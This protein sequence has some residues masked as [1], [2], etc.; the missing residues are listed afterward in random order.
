MQSDRLQSFRD[1]LSCL[2]Y[3]VDWKNKILHILLEVIEYG[4]NKGYILPKKF[5]DA[6]FELVRFSSSE[7]IKTS[8]KTMTKNEFQDFISSFSKEDKYLFLFE[9]LIF[10]GCRIGE[11]CALQWKDF[12]IE[13]KVIHIYKTASSHM[14]TGKIEVTT[15][16]T[17]ASNREIAFTEEF[18]E[19]IISFK[20]SF[21]NVENDRYVFFNKRTPLNQNTIRGVLNRHQKLANIQR[22]FS[23]HEFRHT[24]ITWLLDKCSNLEEIDVV[25][26]RLGHSSLKTTLDVYYHSNPDRQREIASRIDDIIK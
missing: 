15:P 3:K 10:T 17:Y 12:D 22:H 26:K 4:Y 19:K 14:G 2:P 5:Q 6:K 13:K 25:R 16:K 1:Y 20:K 7:T 11:L 8:R 21:I 24:N 9:F 23:P 18:L